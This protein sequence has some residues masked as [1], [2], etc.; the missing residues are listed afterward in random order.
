LG[1]FGVSAP[2]FIEHNHDVYSIHAENEYV[3]MLLEGGCA[4]FGLAL[5]GLAGIGLKARRAWIAAPT[6]A[7]R[8]LVLGASA[9]IVALAIQVLSDFGLHVPAISLLMVV[10]CGHLCWLGAERGAATSPAESGFKTPRSW[11]RVP[12][13]AVMAA[14]A[15][16]ILRGAVQRSQCE[17]VIASAG[18][19]APDTH[20]LTPTLEIGPLEELQQRRMAL[21]RSAPDVVVFAILAHF[22][23]SSL[24][25]TPWSSRFD[26]RQDAGL[27]RLGQV[28]FYRAAVSTPRR[29]RTTPVPRPARSYLS[30]AGCFYAPS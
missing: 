25:F 1:T 5:L 8:A 21:E 9:G 10:L 3:E 14:L 2:L 18:L 17:A 30:S 20:R 15:V 19:T 7:D 13:M 23:C 29:P 6:H 28:G 22:Q 12:I 27:D 11:L 26:H 16:V 24:H 4:G